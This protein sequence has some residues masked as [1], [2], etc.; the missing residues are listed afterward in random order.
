MWLVYLC[1]KCVKNMESN[2][3]ANQTFKSE[4]KFGMTQSSAQ[5]M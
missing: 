2:Q 4:N 5:L 3:D 1:V